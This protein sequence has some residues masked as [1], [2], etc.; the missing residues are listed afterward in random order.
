VT[1]PR[2]DP[3]A[4]VK[5][6]LD[7]G[8]PAKAANLLIGYCEISRLA[9]L[10]EAHP[11]TVL[12]DPAPISTISAISRGTPQNCD[13]EDPGCNQDP[14][15]PPPG[16]PERAALDQRQADTLAGLLKCAL[17]ERQPRRLQSWRD[18]ADR[19]V[20][21]DRCSCCGGREWWLLPSGA[22]GCLRC[23]PRPAGAGNIVT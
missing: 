10:A 20:P 9:G 11:Q 14:P 19:A 2:F 7:A 1:L 5:S 12:S 18:P 21:G 17:P 23:Q 3:W 6:E 16:T 22:G 8:T 4:M 13:F 15:L